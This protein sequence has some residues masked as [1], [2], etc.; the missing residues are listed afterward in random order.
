[1]PFLIVVSEFMAFHSH[2]SPFL[3]Q[4]RRFHP[5]VLAVCLY[6]RTLFDKEN[7]LLISSTLSQPADGL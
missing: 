2:R 7:A 6:K 4:F 1:M 3:P 5:A